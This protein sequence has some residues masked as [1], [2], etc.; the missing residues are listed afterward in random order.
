M[1]LNIFTRIVAEKLL[2]TIITL[3]KILPFAL[4]IQCTEKSVL[5]PTQEPTGNTAAVEN[6]IM[7]EINIRAFSNEGTFQGIVNRLDSIKAL[8]INTIWLMPIYPIGQINTVNSPYCV[9]NYTEVNPEFGTMED[10]KT[11]TKEAHNWKI[12]IIIDWIAN[13]TSWDNPWIQNKS[14]YSQDASG[15]IIHPPGTN[16]QD[17]ADLNYDN[18]EMRKEMIKSMKYWL[19]SADVDGFRCDAA[20]FVPFDF[21]KQ[22]ISDLSNIEGK[23]VIFLAE[24]ERFDHF[25]AGFQMNYSWDFY[26]TIKNVFRDNYLASYIFSTHDAEYK[27]IPAGKHKL[28]FTTNHDESA[29]DATPMTL[30]SGKKGALAAS[31]ITIYLGGVPLIYGS[32][33]V[34]VSGTIP[35]FSRAPIDWSLNPDMLKTYKELLSLYKNSDALRKGR[36]EKFEAV[37]V[38]AFKKVLQEKEFLLIVNVRNNNVTYT[39]PASLTNTTWKSVFDSSFV[40]ITAAVALEPYSYLILTK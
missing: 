32:Q 31:V 36:L 3:I 25:T 2:R 11:L 7:Y 20:D 33:E 9:R 13:H 34:G 17:V 22:A 18:Q 26:S 37:N 29:W 5:E 8:S 15:N 27:N 14:W 38:L 23:S 30:F 16:W 10:F 6:I 19:L 40:E 21:W 39:P 35:F 4:L 1:I 12:N 28:R 24:G